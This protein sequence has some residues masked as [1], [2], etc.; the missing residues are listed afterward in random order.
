MA[1]YVYHL[2]RQPSAATFPSRGRLKTYPFA[3][4][5]GMNGTIDVGWKGCFFSSFA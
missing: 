2:I 4:K 1:P 3:T 5:L